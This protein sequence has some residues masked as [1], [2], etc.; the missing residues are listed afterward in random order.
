[1]PFFPVC[2]TL[3]WPYL[4]DQPS[5]V[6]NAF[7]SSYELRKEDKTIC[8]SFLPLLFLLSVEYEGEEAE[9]FPQ[10]RRFF[11]RICTHG[12]FDIGISAVIVLN[13]ICMAIEHYEQPKVSHIILPTPQVS[14]LEFLVTS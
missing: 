5:C 11:Q 6:G 8:S 10:P 3:K 14:L 2:E 4:T 12:Y 1:M 7:Q 13:V 9:E